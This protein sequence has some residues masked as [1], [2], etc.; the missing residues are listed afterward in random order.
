MSI[1][2]VAMLFA[3]KIANDPDRAYST[4][5][6]LCKENER[7]HA[8]RH[9][10]DKYHNPADPLKLHCYFD[11]DGQCSSCDYAAAERAI[12]ERY[13]KGNPS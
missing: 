11:G 10:F 12:H 1:Y 13:R 4:I 2:K 6:E 3:D 9:H 7:L 8:D 5:L